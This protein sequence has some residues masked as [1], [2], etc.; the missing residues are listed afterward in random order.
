M[1]LLVSAAHAT[2]CGQREHNEDFVGM[3][4]PNEPELSNKGVLAAVADG[5]SGHAGG[6]EAAEYSVRGLLADYYAKPD[7]WPVS[8]ALERVLKA[9][10]SWVQRHGATRP[11]MAGMASTL[12]CL[13]L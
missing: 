1:S 8:K 6:R 2:R 11:E 9:T 12:T 10:N 13:V 3:V 5:V 4:T 7:T